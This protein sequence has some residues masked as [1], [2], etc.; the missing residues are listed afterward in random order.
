VP[1]LYIIIC[2]K[3]GIR[4][5]SDARLSVGDTPG[6]LRSGSH[7]S[8]GSFRSRNAGRTSSRNDIVY[9]RWTTGMLVRASEICR[10]NT[11]L[12]MYQR[13][14][15]WLCALREHPC[16]ANSSISTASPRSGKRR[17]R[18]P[19]LG[20]FLGVLR[21]F[22]ANLPALSHLHHFLFYVYCLTR[23]RSNRR[24]FNLRE[25]YVLRENER[26]MFHHFINSIF[27]Q[28]EVV[29]SGVILHDNF[30]R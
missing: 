16:R 17:T 2:R 11:P 6:G 12:R 26:T 24:T 5:I 27:M 8:R 13:G 20:T 7:Y 4:S 30:T 14:L 3:S 10:I 18:R 19:G 28:K 29:I 9:S 25:Y 22:P 21:P 1:F 23:E 15:L